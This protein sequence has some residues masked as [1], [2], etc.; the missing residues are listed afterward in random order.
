MNVIWCDTE[1]TRIE[2]EEAGAFQI[3]MLFQKALFKC[4]G[5][6]MEDYFDKQYDVYE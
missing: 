4:C 6:R 3:S 1:T 2:V 5:Y